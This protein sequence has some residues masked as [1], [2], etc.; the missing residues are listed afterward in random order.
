MTRIPLRD[1]REVVSPLG[2]HVLAS[3]EVAAA[4]AGAQPVVAVETS[5]VTHGLPYPHCVDVSVDAAGRIGA[6]GV[7]RGAAG[8]VRRS[9]S[10]PLDSVHLTYRR[11]S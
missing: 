8:D 3:D 9:L 5:L 1:V 7:H 6:G 4:L 11:G 2:S 10:G